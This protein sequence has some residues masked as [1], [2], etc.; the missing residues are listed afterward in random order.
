MIQFTALP[1]ETAN[2]YRAGAADAYGNAPERVISTGSGYPCRHCLH[3]APE[4]TEMLLVAHRPFGALQPYA[5]TGPIFLCAKGCEAPRSAGLPEVLT[6]SP[7]YLVKAYTADE[8]ILYGTG[9]VVPWPQLEEAIAKRLENP[10]VAFV[11][12]RS[13]RNNCWLARARRDQD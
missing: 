9:E 1:T 2:A 13:A 8:R 7:D 11:D 3:S 6:V 5:E 10:E 12:V 4:G